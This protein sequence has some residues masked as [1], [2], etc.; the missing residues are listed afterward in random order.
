MRLCR[1]CWEAE[2]RIAE[3]LPEWP[4]FDGMARRPRE[5]C[6]LQPNHCFGLF[7]SGERT[8]E[9]R[10]NRKMLE[11]PCKPLFSKRLQDGSVLLMHG[12]D[13]Q[14]E[15][16]HRVPKEKKAKN[17]NPRLNITFRHHL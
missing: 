7:R 1:R 13:V 5:D 8:M 2:L 15:T 4:R 14:E 10:R 6:E 11:N 9:F 12:W 16:E 3:L 17:L